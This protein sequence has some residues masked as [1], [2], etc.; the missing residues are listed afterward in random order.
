MIFAQC[1]D[2]FARNDWRRIMARA[3][4]RYKTSWADID[5]ALTRGNA[6]LWLASVDDAP[7][8]GLVCR[9]DG[10]TMEVWL[11]GG[12]VLSGCVPFL[13]GVEREAKQYGMTTGR[14]TGRKGWARVLRDDG[15][16]VDGDNLAKEL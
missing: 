1:T 6:M 13:A 11:A 15:W 3:V 16:R 4:E 14:I 10:T 9:R 12:A 5:E 7:V 8:A 2:P